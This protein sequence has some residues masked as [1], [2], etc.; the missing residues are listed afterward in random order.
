LEEGRE[1]SYLVFSPREE[2]FLFCWGRR[3][4]IAF[5]FKEEGPKLGRGTSF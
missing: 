1:L 2:S 3:G 4:L 5:S